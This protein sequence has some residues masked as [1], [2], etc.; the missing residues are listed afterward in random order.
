MKI[1]LL[2]LAFVVFTTPTN[3]YADISLLVHESK[4]FTEEITGVGHITIYL[5][6][7]CTDAPLVLRQ[8][9]T[10]ELKGVVISTY[11]GLGINTEYKWFAIPVLAYLYGIET[12]PQIPLYANGNIRRFLLESNRAKYLSKQIPRLKDEKLPSGRWSELFGT[13]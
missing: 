1:L 11:P 4:G 12:E 5:S 13:T 6:N 3:V 2:I 10:D 9:N 7:L 8:C